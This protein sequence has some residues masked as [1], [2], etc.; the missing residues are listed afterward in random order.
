M[1]KIERLQSTTD[2]TTLSLLD[3]IV[4]LNSIIVK[5]KNCFNC[6]YLKIVIKD[7][8]LKKCFNNDK[9]CR[10]YL[11]DAGAKDLWEMKE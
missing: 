3:E 11:S 10:T 9:C 4:R 5:M 6:K 1:N 7:S 2:I 8:T